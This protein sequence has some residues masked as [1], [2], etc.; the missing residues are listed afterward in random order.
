MNISLT[1][2]KGAWK[3]YRRT[4][5]RRLHYVKSTSF[6]IAVCH[7]ETAVKYGWTFRYRGFTHGQTLALLL[8]VATEPFGEQSLGHQLCKLGDAYNSCA[9]SE[10]WCQRAGLSKY[11]QSCPNIYKLRNI[12]LHGTMRQ[13]CFVTI[14][15]I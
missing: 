11:V 7:S 3:P 12:C 13:C 15:C 8:S 5:F 14:V 10:K 1:S 6:E 4:C 9:K 2:I